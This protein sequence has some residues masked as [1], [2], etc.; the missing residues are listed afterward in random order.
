MSK[1][2]VVTCPKFI[3]KA[4]NNIELSIDLHNSKKGMEFTPVCKVSKRLWVID[5]TILDNG[6]KTQYRYNMGADYKEDLELL[7]QSMIHHKQAKAFELME[8]I[9]W[10]DFK[11]QRSQLLG[12]I[13]SLKY[14]EKQA[15]SV[16]ENEQQS[17][18]T[19]Q[20]EGLDGIVELCDHIVDYG[21]DVLGLDENKICLRE[22]E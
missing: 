6:A 13:E 12:A 8:S 14:E 21:V 19:N 3:L 2:T 9:D 17:K 11:Q 4:L 18:Y 15:S 1:I 20:I 22:E 5:A 7:R 10:S 16:G